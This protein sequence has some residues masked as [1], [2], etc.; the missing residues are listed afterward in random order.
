MQSRKQF[1][2]SAKAPE[3]MTMCLNKVLFESA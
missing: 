1:T 2:K 3:C